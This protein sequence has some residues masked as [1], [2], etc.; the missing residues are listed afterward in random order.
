MGTEGLN[1]RRSG[2]LI[3]RWVS[4]TTGFSS[5]HPSNKHNPRLRDSV[6]KYLSTIAEGEESPVLP[7][8]DDITICREDTSELS[9]NMAEDARFRVIEG[10]V[11]DMKS[12]I[13]TVNKK[14]DDLLESFARLDIQPRETQQPTVPAVTPNAGTS[15]AK[16]QGT[17]ND[18]HVNQTNVYTD[19]NQQPLNNSVPVQANQ[20]RPRPHLHHMVGRQ[21]TED[22]FIQREMDRDRFDYAQNGRYMYTSDISPRVMAK[23]YMYLYREGLS[24]MKQKLDARNTMSFNEYIDALLALLADTR[25][26]RNAD[27]RDIMHHASKVARDALERP[28]Q[29]V[30][31]WTQFVWDSVESGAFGWEDRDIIQ[32]E[33]VRLCMTSA[34]TSSNAKLGDTRRQSPPTQVI[35]RAY[36]TRMGCSHRESHG[37]VHVWENHACSYCDSVGRTCFHSV[38]ECERRLAHT[39]N[40]YPSQGRNRQF[41]YQNNQQNASQY[42]QSFNNAQQYSKNGQ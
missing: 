1:T 26:Y 27:Y 34:Y 41:Q 15:N 40:D 37:D 30:R 6:N 35:C 21:L 18:T 39:R 25:A 42:S 33:R 19:R 10:E 22:E 4:I 17:S 16:A 36:N 7:V 5:N 38:R 23:P 3:D 31:R 2:R 14:L 13:G 20:S 8:S 32:E 12:E 11:N 9:I 24:S 28:W 29:A